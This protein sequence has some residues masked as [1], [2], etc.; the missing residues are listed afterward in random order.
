MRKIDINKFA[1]AKG[2][3]D[4][5]AINLAISQECFEAENQV[6]KLGDAYYE[7]DTEKSEG[8]SQ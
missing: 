5:G 2:Y 4:M 8:N 3:V 1:F 6:M 7:M